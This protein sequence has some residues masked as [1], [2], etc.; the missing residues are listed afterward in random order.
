[1]ADVLLTVRTRRG[2]S[3]NQAP[4]RHA[5]FPTPGGVMPW[6]MTLCGIPAYTVPWPVHAVD[7]EQVA[8]RVRLKNQRVAAVPV[9]DP[10]HERACERCAHVAAAHFAARSTG[11][12]R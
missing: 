10:G 7:G 6:G 11:S 9:F 1:M 4:L 12:T 2:G 3:A 5:A 8:G